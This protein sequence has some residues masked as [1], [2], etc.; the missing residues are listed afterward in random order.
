MDLPPGWARAE[1]RWLEPD[2]VPAIC[3]L[4][5]L[6]YEDCERE[7]YECRQEADEEAAER[8]FEARRD[9]WD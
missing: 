8:R 5:D 3:R 7:P 1:A 4:C 6:W 9:R 2:D